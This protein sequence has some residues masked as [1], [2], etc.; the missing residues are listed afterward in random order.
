M[1]FVCYCSDRTSNADAGLNC[2]RESN[3][4]IEYI[5]SRTVQLLHQLADKGYCDYYGGSNKDSVYNEVQLSAR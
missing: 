4:F 5:L 1:E 2:L 3:D